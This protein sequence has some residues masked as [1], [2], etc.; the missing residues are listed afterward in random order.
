MN[1]TYEVLE[2]NRIKEML[3]ERA[4]T[5]KAKERLGQLEPILSENELMHRKAETTQARKILEQMGNPPLVSMKNMEGFLLWRRAE[6][7]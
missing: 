7:F 5:E 3:K 1:Q 4:L 6:G 2:F